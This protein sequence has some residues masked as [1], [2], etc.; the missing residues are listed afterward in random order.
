MWFFI[1]VNN[2]VFGTFA[3]TRTRAIV[4]VAPHWK[5]IRSRQHKCFYFFEKYIWLLREINNLFYIFEYF[6]KW[7]KFWFHGSFG[8]LLKIPKNIWNF[9]FFFLGT[10][11]LLVSVFNIFSVYHYTHGIYILNSPTYT[12]YLNN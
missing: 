11:I 2:L 6:P 5:L 7:L 1:V 9:F 8:M 4:V 12:F 3:A 10:T